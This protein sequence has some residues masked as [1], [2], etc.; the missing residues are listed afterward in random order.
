[1]ATYTPPDL[2]QRWAK[3]DLTA[4]QA[5]GHIMQN[6]LALFNRQNELEKRLRALEQPPRPEEGQPRLP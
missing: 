6:Q 3:G 4:D 2:I 5:I 1:M